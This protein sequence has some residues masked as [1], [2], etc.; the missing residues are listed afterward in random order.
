MKL[1]DLKIHILYNFD[2]KHEHSFGRKSWQ[3]SHATKECPSESSK[4]PTGLF[5]YRFKWKVLFLYILQLFTIFTLY[6][7]SCRI[8]L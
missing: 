3:S 1:G 7:H 8:L 4:G 5:I 2:P 6:I